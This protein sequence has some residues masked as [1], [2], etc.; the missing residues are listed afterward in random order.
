MKRFIWWLVGFLVLPF[1]VLIALATGRK[2]GQRVGAASEARK[3]DDKEV[4]E[5][6]PDRLHD[7]LTQ[8]LDREEKP[9]R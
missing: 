1:A 6:N 4:D 2:E 7:L 8:P 3:R 9:L 5:A